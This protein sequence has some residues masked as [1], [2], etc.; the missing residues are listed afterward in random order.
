MNFEYDI[1]ISYG[2]LDDEDPAGEEKGWVDLLTERLPVLIASD[3]GYKPKIWRDEQSL[4]GN[5]RLRGALEEAVSKSLLFVPVISPRYV[6]SDWCPME[7][8]AFCCS[9][10]PEGLSADSTLSRIFKVIKKP[11]LLSQLSK[12]EPEHLRDLI[13]YSFYKMEG[14]MPTEF[15]P[16]V[17]A[18]KDQRYWGAL[19]RLAWDIAR[20][21]STLKPEGEMMPRAVAPITVNVPAPDPTR[22]PPAGTTEPVERNGAGASKFVYLAE[23]TGDLTSER[24]LVS[25]ELR[26]RGFGVLPEQKL[27]LDER[28][29]TEEAVREAMA[30]CALSVHLVGARYGSTPEDDASS[31]IRIQEELAAERGAKDSAFQ[32][33]IWLPPGLATP[34][35]EITDA[36]QKSYVEELQTRVTAGAELLQM[37]IQDLKTRVV[38]KLTPPADVRSR[39]KRRAKAKRVYLICENRDRSFVLPIRNYLFKEKFEVITWLDEGASEK[40]MDYHRKN[41]KECDAALIYFGNGD[42]PWVRKNIEDLEKAYG[43]GRD[44]DWSASAVYVGQPPDDW[45]EG[46]YTNDVPYLI[47]NFKEFNPEDLREFVSAVRA[48]EGGQS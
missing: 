43:Y 4:R 17:V 44:D 11:L 5:A 48:A 12:K 19:S 29:R 24:D 36:R 13:G 32:R 8:E 30:R 38:E 20:M 42:E 41:L 39:D 40:L 14:D 15:S 34:A 47:H 46:F 7:L 23:T 18:G 16:D 9:P 26:Q 33:L 22:N 28:R 45:K 2:H 10:L 25:D 3:L 1:F 37:N 35:L 31:V 27:P 6:R 21:L